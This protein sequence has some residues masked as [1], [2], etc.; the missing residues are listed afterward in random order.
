METDAATGMDLEGNLAAWNKKI[1]GHRDNTQLSALFCVHIH[2]HMRKI[3]RVC[4]CP[5]RRHTHM[6]HVCSYGRSAICVS[7]GVR[8]HACAHMVSSPLKAEA[9]ATCLVALSF[10]NEQPTH[11]KVQV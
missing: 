1:S 7:M 10:K 2:E 6:P 3:Q 11:L 4:G 8:A 5:R 9:S